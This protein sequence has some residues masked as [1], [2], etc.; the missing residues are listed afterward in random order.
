M[1]PSKFIV[2][3]GP[4]G[5]GKTT[6]AKAIAQWM[7][8]ELGRRTAF[9]Q[10]PGGTDFANA[11]RA[12]VFSG[13]TKSKQAEA[14]GL[15]TAEVDC[16]ESVILPNLLNGNHVIGD[17][18]LMSGRIY[19]GFLRG[20]PT[21]SINKLID[22]AITHPRSIPDVHI[23]LNAQPEILLER[24]INKIEEAR[25]KA[26]STDEGKENEE[27]IALEYEAELEALN[28]NID[29]YKHAWSAY[30][31]CTSFAAGSPC[32]VLDT[33]EK[34]PEECIQRVREIIMQGVLS[35]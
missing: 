22:A 18:W 5:A 15:L 16:F 23:V 13:A 32:I 11:L 29:F 14:M 17:R 19:Q 6:V 30:Q 3:E 28:G 26:E 9:V 20:R 34:T 12:T 10:S 1:T 24:T 4:D 7:S 2:F 27:Q 21:E 33:S 35:I 25:E 31:K 8:K